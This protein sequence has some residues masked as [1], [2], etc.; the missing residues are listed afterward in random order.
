MGPAPCPAGRGRGN[1]ALGTGED[2]PG[3][4]RAG[5]GGREAGRAS[6]VGKAQAKG[7]R[8]GGAP[9]GFVRSK[10]SIPV[11]RNT[12]SNNEIVSIFMSTFD[13]M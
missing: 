11:F 1:G 7:Y 13:P 10:E 2:G 12:K 4:R 8:C 5:P 3:A 6:L 9:F